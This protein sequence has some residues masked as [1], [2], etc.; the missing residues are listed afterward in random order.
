MLLV[1][2]VRISGEGGEP[3]DI[4]ACG[5][6]IIAIG[7]HIECGLPIERTVDGGGMTALP[8][9]IDAHVH[10]TGGGGEGGFSNQVPPLK[11]SALIDAGVTT[12]VGLLG[13]DGT[14]RSVENLVAKT[15]AFNEEGWCAYCL[16][17]SYELPSPTITGSVKRDIVFIQEIIGVKVAISDHRSSGPTKAELVRLA[18]EARLG[19][20]LSGKPGVVH[21]HLGSGRDE[22]RTIIEIVRTTDIPIGIF[23]PTHLG[24]HIDMAAEFASLGGYADFTAGTDPDVTAAT[25][26]EARSVM[27]HEL[28]TLSSDGNGSFPKWNERKEMIGISAGK[29][30]NDHEVIRALVRGQG[31]ELDDA[32][33][34][35]TSSPAASLGLWPYKGRIA[36]GSCADI[37]LLDED[38]RIDTVIAGGRLYKEHGTRIYTPK[39]ED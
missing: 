27:P 20:M 9:Y 23:K 35:L 26:M 10:I 39:F 21:M 38:L 29:I 14:T 12:V 15:K 24:G 30:T 34:I 11:L 37:L 36:V 16:T 18:C 13:T 2:D 32:V 17:G 25:I 33:S 22:L 3:V 7:P 19:G 28:I 31:L 6:D 1:R 5:R 4:L 8:G